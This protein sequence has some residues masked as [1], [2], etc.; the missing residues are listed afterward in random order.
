M[1]SSGTLSSAELLLWAMHRASPRPPRRDAAH[2]AVRAR[3]RRE[4]RTRSIAGKRALAPAGLGDIS[5][6]VQAR[7]TAM[8]VDS[9]AEQ[10]RASYTS[11]ATGTCRPP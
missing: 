11:C 2:R 10:S 3:N 7:H 8:Q 9:P 4:F 1:R 6:P 5:V